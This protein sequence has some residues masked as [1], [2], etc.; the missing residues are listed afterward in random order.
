MLSILNLVTFYSV[1]WIFLMINVWYVFRIRKMDDR[2]L[3]RKE[4]TYVVAVWLIFDSFQ[5]IFYG[6]SQQS[7]CQI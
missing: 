4:M 5:Y 1:N 2:L 7:R 3:I 6:L